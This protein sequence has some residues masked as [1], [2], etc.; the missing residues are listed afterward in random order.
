MKW[1]RQRCQD[2]FKTFA[3]LNT[4]YQFTRHVTDQLVAEGDWAAGIADVTMVLSQPQALGQCSAWLASSLPGAATGCPC[5][6]TLPGRSGQTSGAAS[7]S[8][9]T[10]ST[11]CGS[12]SHSTA[13]DSAA[14]RA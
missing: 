10:A 13:I 4:M 3:S 11:A 8:A 1:M 12:A 9:A 5:A 6:A 7:S 14:S 2:V